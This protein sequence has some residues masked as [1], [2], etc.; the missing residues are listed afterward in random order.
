MKRLIA[1]MIALM[2]REDPKRIQHFMKVYAFA[3]AIGT[4][5]AL[6]DVRI[7]LF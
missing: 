3:Q 5:E 2:M 7:N 4:L 1:Q 6:S